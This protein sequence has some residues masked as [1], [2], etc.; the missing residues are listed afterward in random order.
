[1]N[2]FVRFARQ[3]RIIWHKDMFENFAMKR[4]HR[5]LLVPLCWASVSRAE[6][7]WLNRTAQT[8][9]FRL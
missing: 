8:T 4:A 6:D 9:L 5:N 3:I 1:M 7:S 2:F